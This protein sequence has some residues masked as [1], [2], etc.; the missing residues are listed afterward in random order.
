MTLELK[1]SFDDKTYRH[2]LN[3]FNIVLHCHHYMCLTTK[4]AEDFNDIGGTRILTE[5]AEDTIRPIFDEYA[6][7]HAI[8]PGDARL[9][10]AAEF[11]SAM[12][13]GRMDTSGTANAGNVTLQKSHIDQGWV[14]KW[15]NNTK[16]INHF[17]RGY[18]AAMFAAAFDKPARS[19]MVTET[20]AIVTGKP[21][22]AF[23]IVKQ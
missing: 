6:K 1:H 7:T 4:L 8:A 9:K 18:I 13:L 17:T 19:Y 12:G 10:M 16:P 14:K 23:A 5:T 15:G 11:Y 2:F 3:G 22:S 20:E 21:A